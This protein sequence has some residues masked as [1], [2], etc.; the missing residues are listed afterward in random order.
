M[1]VI[2]ASKWGVFFIIVS[3]DMK[4]LIGLCLYEKYEATRS[5]KSNHA[6]FPSFKLTKQIIEKSIF[7]PSPGYNTYYIINQKNI[8][9][10]I[11]NPIS[12]RGNS[13]QPAGL[14]GVCI[15]LK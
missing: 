13:L 6:A 14:L 9:C 5:Q 4:P 1:K 15:M 8:G 2:P 3:L 7:P 11:H 10:S 12:P